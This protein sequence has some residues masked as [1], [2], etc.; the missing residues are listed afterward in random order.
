EW[1]QSSRFEMLMATVLC[2]N[3]LWM[4]MELQVDGSIAGIGLGVVSQSALPADWIA[5]YERFFL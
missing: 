1:L 5:A 3:V 2:L 4:A